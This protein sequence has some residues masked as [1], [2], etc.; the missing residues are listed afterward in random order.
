VSRS[1]GSDP[2]DVGERLEM[3][4]ARI[5]RAGG[6]PD[7][8]K[9]LAVTK[10]FSSA[11]VD[12]A[13]AA[14]LAELGENYAQELVAK[15]TGPRG[16][17]VRWHFLGAVQ[18]NKVRAMAP[19]VSSW[20]SVSRPVEGTAITRLRPGASVLVEVNVTGEPGR[21]GCPPEATGALVE[22]LREEGCDVRGLMTVAPLGG[23]ARAVFAAV[24]RLA[25]DLELPERSMGMTDDLEDAVAE[26]STMVRVGR[27][28]FGA[29][30]PR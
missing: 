23:G 7:A 29:R 9:V 6:D 15:A 5:V 1:A 10:G 2:S 12:A 16:D 27:A 8:V 14:G 25:D 11:A 30:P 24:H 26:G 20:D 13:L 4:R 22:Q 21:N 17:E 18:R 3:V 19:Y 28:L